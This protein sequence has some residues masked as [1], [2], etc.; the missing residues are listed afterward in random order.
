M[1]FVICLSPLKC[2]FRSLSHL[3]IRLFVFLLLNVK[4]SLCSLNSSLFFFFSLLSGLPF[5]SLSSIFHRI[6]DVNN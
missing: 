4:D 1:L 6:E 2:L 5:L 3:L